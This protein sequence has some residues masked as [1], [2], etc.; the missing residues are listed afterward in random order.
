[1]GCYHAEQVTFEEGVRCVVMPCCGFTFDADHSDD[2]VE[3]PRWTCPV[4]EP[5]SD[6]VRI[7]KW[8]ADRYAATLAGKSV[9]DA[10]EALE[11]ARGIVEQAGV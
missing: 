9:R 8:V 2:K 10:D 6:A 4:C 5:P 1:M 7:L 11:A 3:P